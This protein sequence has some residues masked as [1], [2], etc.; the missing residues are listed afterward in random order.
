[1]FQRLETRWA[2]IDPRAKNWAVDRNTISCPMET[3]NS[4]SQG[5]NSS[6][7]VKWLIIIFTM[8]GFK[9]DKLAISTCRTGCFTRPDLILGRAVGGAVDWTAASDR[10][11]WV[12][13]AVGAVAGRQEG[14]YE[15]TGQPAKPPA[16][17]I[18][19]T[20]VK[21]GRLAVTAT[22]NTGL[23]V[24]RSRIVLKYDEIAPQ[25]DIPQ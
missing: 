16:G 9:E 13:A 7:L 14:E 22:H 24:R 2:E 12:C 19:S 4:I 25:D 6:E 10:E 1:M 8:S 20:T 15:A 5:R 11:Q 17:R 3:V 23:K 18:F 21:C